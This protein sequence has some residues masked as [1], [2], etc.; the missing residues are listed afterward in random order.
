MV[1]LRLHR[2]NPIGPVR[3]RWFLTPAL[4]TMQLRLSY[5]Q[6]LRDVVLAC[7]KFEP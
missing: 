5:G 1:V 4:P 3:L 7:P 2:R 6:S